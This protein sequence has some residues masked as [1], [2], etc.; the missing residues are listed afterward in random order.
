MLQA[1]KLFKK[2]ADHETCMNSGGAVLYPEF[3][4]RAEKDSHIELFAPWLEYSVTKIKE[5]QVCFFFY[6][7]SPSQF[8]IRE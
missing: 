2:M 6:S 8:D 3:V 1:K 4:Q 5:V 7:E